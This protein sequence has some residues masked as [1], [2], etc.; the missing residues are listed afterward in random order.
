MTHEELR[1]L[2]AAHALDALGPAEVRELEAHLPTCETCRRELAVLRG[3]AG[4]LATAVPLVSPP[5]ALRDRILDAVAPRPRVV[6]LPRIWSPRLLSRGLAAAAVLVVILVGLNVSLN[7][8]VAKLSRDNQAM[9][10][11]L[12][13]IND[14][15]GAQ[16]RVLA[17]LANPASRTTPLAGS[18][19]ASVRFV[20]HPATRQGALVVS[21]LRDPGA[22]FVYQ[23]WLVAGQEPQSVGVFRPVQGR[24]IIVPVTADFSRYQVV[25][26]SVE[27]GPSG[28]SRPSAAPILAGTL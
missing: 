6:A 1:E 19:Q 4:D 17:L 23:L 26:I 14:R 16:E 11:Q 9:N 18:V 15:L 27:R 12:A 5:A 24:P 21:D 10:Q 28:V 13:A 22:E 25:A 7:R 20:Y 2:L 3:V 8:Q